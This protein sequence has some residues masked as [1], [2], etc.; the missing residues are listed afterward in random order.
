MPEILIFLKSQVPNRSK[1]L[2]STSIFHVTDQLKDLISLKTRSKV[3]KT[4]I[5]IPGVYSIKIEAR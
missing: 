5:T 1:S 4:L 3:K 2:F